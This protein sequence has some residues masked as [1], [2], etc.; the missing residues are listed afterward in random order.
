LLDNSRYK[1]IGGMFLGLRDGGVQVLSPNSMILD[2][3]IKLTNK[4]SYVINA[5][6]KI[7]PD[8]SATIKGIVFNYNE[9]DGSYMVLDYRYIERLKGYYLSLRCYDGKS[10]EKTPA[11]TGIVNLKENA[12]YDFKINVI[13][14]KKTTTV[15]LEYKTGSDAYKCLSHVFETS[16]SGRMA[17]YYCPVANNMQ[18]SEIVT[19]ATNYIGAEDTRYQLKTGAFKEVEETL[20]VGMSSNFMLDKTVDVSNKA[21]YT[22]KASYKIVPDKTATIKGIVFNYNESDGSYMVLD[23][24][25]IER[26]SSYYLSVRCYDGK[27]WDTIPAWTGIVQLEE[28]AWYDFE[29]SVVSRTKSTDILLGYKKSTDTTYQ[30]VAHRFD[31]GMKGRMAGYCSWSNDTNVIQFKKLIEKKSSETGTIWPDEWME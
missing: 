30:S 7:V 26:L 16:M 15:F 23:Y 19:G 24:R 3:N 17:G 4:N 9:A 18:F 13:N 5:S 29:I 10:W 27:G 8:K 12:W 14:G 25:Y 22:I 21:T 6:Y 2:R 1:T 20:V 11:W 31:V 28:G